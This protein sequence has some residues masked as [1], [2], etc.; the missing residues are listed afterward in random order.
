MWIPKLFLLIFSFLVEKKTMVDQKTVHLFFM[1]LSEEKLNTTTVYHVLQI[2]RNIFVLFLCFFAVP[3]L[4]TRFL[5]TL[6]EIKS[7]LN[8]EKNETIR[9]LLQTFI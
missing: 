8:K 7:P 2:K 1:F 6:N 9:D 3:L 4:L 5:K